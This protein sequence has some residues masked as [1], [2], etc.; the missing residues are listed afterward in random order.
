[1]LQKLLDMQM[2][3]FLI[4]NAKIALK[5]ESLIKRAVQ[6]S[7]IATFYA[8][9][10]FAPM[11]EHDLKSGEGGMAKVVQAR[12]KLVWDITGYYLINMRKA[13][14]S[15]AR[16]QSSMDWPKDPD[17]QNKLKAAGIPDKVSIDDKAKYYTAEQYETLFLNG[18][19]SSAYGG[20]PW[21]D[22]A[23]LFG[24]LGKARDE[25]KKEVV[26]P[27]QA[28]RSFTSGQ[29]SK[30]MM[31]ISTIIDR[32]HQLEHNTGSLFTYFPG[33][34]S[35]WIG[36]LL[37]EKAL[38]NSVQVLRDNLKD[39]EIGQGGEKV[40]MKKVV[41]KY[42]K[43]PD[44]DEEEIY[45]Q[46]G[47][48]EGSRQT[49]RKLQYYNK[50][51]LYEK[52]KLDESKATKALSQ[53]EY[54]MQLKNITESHE[55]NVAELKNPLKVIELIEHNSPMRE[56]AVNGYVKLL[57]RE[58]NSEAL[59][60]L[61]NGGSMYLSGD[62]IL[63]I[64]NL[65]KPSLLEAA[66]L[67]AIQ[68]KFGVLSKNDSDAL[69]TLQILIP[70]IGKLYEAGHPSA[71][72]FDCRKIYARLVNNGYKVDEETAKIFSTGVK[73]PDINMIQEIVNNFMFKN[74]KEKDKEDVL[75][76]VRSDFKDK[77]LRNSNIARALKSILKDLVSSG[78]L[79]QVTSQN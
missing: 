70:I 67:G 50:M 66:A 69:K 44:V 33:G 49:S 56:K 22:I 40:D 63:K 37:T 28:I 14:T 75:N 65:G 31:E 68:G 78:E 13:L 10:L 47:E 62:N 43:T 21:A 25:I 11:A 39:I 6:K 4:K 26:Y 57:I 46:I 42:N 8:L 20:K 17:K 19:W 59:E 1:M 53:Q 30:K 24:E 45:E 58:G 55:K 71:K 60:K 7:D 38:I 77:V 34:E 74:N 12:N 64:V 76:K 73:P 5:L 23:H 2:G 41:E 54:D 9:N 27:H 48:V 51:Y 61:I 52:N 35:A 29:L 79:N 3:A 16:Q 15:E 36:E 18:I 72:F 32:I